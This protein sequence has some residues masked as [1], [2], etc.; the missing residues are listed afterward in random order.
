MAA[1]EVGRTPEWG[2]ITLG[3]VGAV[4]GGSR[5]Q[6]PAMVGGLA[7]ANALMHTFMEAFAEAGIQNLEVI[8][9]AGRSDSPEPYL[10]R[11]RNGK[12]NAR[13]TVAMEEYLLTAKE[14]VEPLL[15]EHYR[16]LLWIARAALAK[17]AKVP[18]ALDEAIATA[19]LPR[20]ARPSNQG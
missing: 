19:G 18:A 16:Q 5:K 10:G 4:K 2:P 7:R 11:R 14:G 17:Y 9:M 12:L 8:V 15:E 20:N 3:F 1:D 6:G 13:V